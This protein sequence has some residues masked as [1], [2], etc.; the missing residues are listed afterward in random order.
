MITRWITLPIIAALAAVSLLLGLSTAN[1]HWPPTASQGRTI[2]PMLERATP[3]VV[4]IA[5]RTR[6]P[7]QDNPLLRDP[8]FRFFFD[9]PQPRAR[10]SQSLG[11]GV[12]VDADKGLLLTNHHVIDKATEISV[13]LN[14]GRVL[15]AELVGSDAE[16]DIAV[17]RVTADNLTAV[18]FGN[19][20]AVRVGDFVVAIGNPFGL[21]QTV[22]S[23]IISALGRSGLGIEGYED[24][25]QTDASIN[26]GNSGGALVDVDGQLIGINT[27]II[28]PSGGNVGIGFA[29]PAR[30][31]RALMEQIVEYGAVRRGQLGIAAQDLTPAIAEALNARRTRGAVI[32]EVR[33]DSAAAAAGIQPGDIVIAAD[34]RPINSAA[35]LR[36]AIGLVRVGDALRLTTLREGRERT[37]TATIPEHTARDAQQLS[38]LLG[39]ATLAEIEPGHPLYGRVN[40]VQISRIERNTPAAQAGLRPGDIISSVN[41][42]PVRSLDEFEAATQQAR[43]QLLLNIRRG[44]QA[45]F[46]MLR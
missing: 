22:T 27:A 23:G 33:A 15:E 16:S 20:D 18:P 13:T 4:N 45:F 46:L 39:G 1:A 2:A 5:T 42:Q 3:G 30:M 44:S 29:I 24:F 21:G 14:D 9:L 36:N 35:D 28:G 17:L 11:S 7:A 25:I 37:V 34:G 26:P 8:F 32:A 12:I 19:S 6:L 31:A 10:E 40:G 43:G 41:R 38:A